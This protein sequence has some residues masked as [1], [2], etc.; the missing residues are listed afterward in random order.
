[1]RCLALVGVVVLLL[2]PTAAAAKVRRV[3][4]TSPVRT[5]EYAKLTIAVSPTAVVCT[6]TVTYK[7][8]TSRAKG[9]GPKKPRAGRVTWRWRVEA[10]TTPGRWPILV[11]CGRAGKL[12]TTFLVTENC[13]LDPGENPVGFST[14]NRYTACV[15]V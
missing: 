2:L 12:R 1:M 14:A 3:S 6:I 10:N 8:V 9:L 7:E 5:G 15:L 13:L 11:D 4:L